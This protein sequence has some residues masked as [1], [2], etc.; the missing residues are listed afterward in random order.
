MHPSVIAVSLTTISWAMSWCWCE[1]WH[2]PSDA[3]V[4]QQAGH[5]H[6]IGRV[7]IWCTR[8]KGGDEVV[9]P[10]L[11]KDRPIGLI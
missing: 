9:V 4:W 8:F 10:I 11:V 2:W 6:Q 3:S 7:N 1:E 5:H